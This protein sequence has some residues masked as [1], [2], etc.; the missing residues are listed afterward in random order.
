VAGIKAKSILARSKIA[1][2]FFILMPPVYFLSILMV[3]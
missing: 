3:T 1:K 2:D